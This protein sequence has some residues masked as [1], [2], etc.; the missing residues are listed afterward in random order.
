[1]FLDASELRPPLLRQ[2]QLA[3]LSACATGGSDTSEGLGDP[4]SLARAFLDAGVP[5]VVASRWDVNSEVTMHFMKE[6]YGA[7]QKGAQV[8]AALADA[9]RVIRTAK[10]TNHPY[11]WAAFSA[12]G[13]T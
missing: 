4:D 9:A 1:M 5:H 13:K 6:F 3:V 7:I 11:Y 8:P 2:I 12:F 10:A